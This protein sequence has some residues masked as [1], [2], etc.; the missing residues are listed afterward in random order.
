MPENAATMHNVIIED[1]KKISM[2][3]ITDVGSFDEETLNIQSQNGCITVHGENLQ[4][5]KLSLDS[6]ELC[7][8]GI[9]N[10]LVYSAPSV[11]GKSLFSK[12]FG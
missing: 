7:A 6:G 10:S 2:T 12:M 1:R 4:I 9:I 5:T 11:K 3:G 8:E